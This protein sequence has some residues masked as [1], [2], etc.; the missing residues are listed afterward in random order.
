[1]PVGQE[2]AAF[3]SL[4]DMFAGYTYAPNLK[5][6][7]RSFTEDMA[8]VMNTFSPIDVDTKI[9]KGGLTR[10]PLSEITGRTF[11]VLAPLVAVE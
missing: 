7:D 10:D 6:V 1:M 5:P 9:T 2:L 3:L 4:G 11:S 8:G